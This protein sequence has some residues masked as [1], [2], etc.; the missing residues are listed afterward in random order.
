VDGGQR[1]ADDGG[2]E[3][4]DSRPEHSGGEHPSAARR[5][6]DELL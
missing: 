5:L 6:Q 3:E 2:I 4:G 1:D